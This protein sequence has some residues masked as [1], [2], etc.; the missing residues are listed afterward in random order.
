MQSL[1]LHH[2]FWLD[3]QKQKAYGY[4]DGKKDGKC[5][6]DIF[7]M[8]PDMSLPCYTAKEQA[9]ER[10]HFFAQKCCGSRIDEDGKVVKCGKHFTTKSKAKI[11]DKLDYKV[12]DIT[13][14]WGCP[15]A[16]NTEYKCL[17]A[18]CS[19]CI[20]SMKAKAVSEAEKRSSPRS[21]QIVSGRMHRVK[22][23]D[24]VGTKRNLNQSQLRGVI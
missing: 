11:N 19:P 20:A 13:Q 23:S 21:K 8:V 14:V 16:F 10:G 9:T 17:L 4:K 1:C 3:P 18:Y 6:H 22:Q 12:T 7:D 15:C 2:N 5:K 24:M